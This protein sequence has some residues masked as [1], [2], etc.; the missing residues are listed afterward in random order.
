MFVI[1]TCT[2]AL[3]TMS[4]RFSPS[5]L[6]LESRA[7]LRRNRCNPRH[8][9][10]KVSFGTRATARLA[11][12]LCTARR[13]RR[14]FCRVSS[15]VEIAND[16]L[17]SL[18]ESALR[19]RRRMASNGARDIRHSRRRRFQSPERRRLEISLARR[20]LPTVFRTRRWWDRAV[21]R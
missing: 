15:W 20:L 19:R 16:R 21:Q 9:R 12:C 6:S 17:N 14:G 4:H 8:R 18:D 2:R 5:P 7:V 10:R 1:D 11:R 13:A 3:A